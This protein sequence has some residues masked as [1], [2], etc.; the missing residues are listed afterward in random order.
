MKKNAAMEKEQKAVIV[1]ENP[2]PQV[3]L[4]D[5]VMQVVRPDSAADRLLR[6]GSKGRPRLSDC[7]TDQLRPMSV[8]SFRHNSMPGLMTHE[9]DHTDSKLFETKVTVHR[10]MS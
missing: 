1:I 3:K 8:E 7:S 2:T 10:S 5:T 6:Y 4:L 9:L